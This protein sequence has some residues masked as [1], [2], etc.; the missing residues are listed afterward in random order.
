MTEQP[1]ER[2]PEPPR[3]GGKARRAARASRRLTSTEVQMTLALMALRHWDR[4]AVEEQ[5]RFRSLAERSSALEPDERRELDGLWK[6]MKIKRLVAEAIRVLTH[7]S[8]V[9]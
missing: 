7:S 5:E 4:L 9:G 3:S 1:D 6:R 2:T 8:P